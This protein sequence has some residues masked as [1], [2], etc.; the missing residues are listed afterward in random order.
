MVEVFKTNVKDRGQAIL[1]MERIHKHFPGYHANFDLEDCDRIL[2]V[3]SAA[4]AV[5]ACRLIDLLKELGCHAEVLPDVVAAGG[6]GGGIF[7]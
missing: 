5:D 3:K 4:G 6:F 7:L 2:R 1:L